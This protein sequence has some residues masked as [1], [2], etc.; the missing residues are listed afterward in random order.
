MGVP[1]LRGYLMVSVFLLVVKAI[2][3]GGGLG[4]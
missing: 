4:H 1:L 2:E 3:L